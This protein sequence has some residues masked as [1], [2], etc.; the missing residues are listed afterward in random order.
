MRAP[1]HEVP[2]RT[3]HSSRPSSLNHPPPGGRDSESE[4][5]H[6]SVFLVRS[7]VWIQP[8]VCWVLLPVWQPLLLPLMLPLCW[9][10]SVVVMLQ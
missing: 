10:L 6:R 3:S 2:T 7:P 9:G 4:S 8:L 1:Q 5:G